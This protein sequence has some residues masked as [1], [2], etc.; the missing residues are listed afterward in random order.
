M[1][2]AYIGSIA[3]VLIFTGCSEHTLDVTP[4]I[5]QTKRNLF[6]PCQI[7]YK[8]DLYD[9]PSSLRDVNASST[10]ARY[11]VEIK[12]SHDSVYIKML[13][14]LNPMVWFGYPLYD[15]TV[16]VEGTLRLEEGGEVQE[17]RAACTSLYS[18]SIYTSRED[19]SQKGCVEAVRD[20]INTQLIYYKIGKK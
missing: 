4:Q 8:G 3:A 20:N 1:M 14:Y 17:F 5:T 16:D 9:L 6:I 13:R 18:R 2:K 10:V 11:D 7:V 15:Q 19:T 12:E